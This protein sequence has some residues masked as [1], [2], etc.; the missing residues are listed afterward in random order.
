MQA[1][2]R[3][4]VATGTRAD[5][6]LLSPLC[7]RLQQS[8]S[9]EL[10]VVAANMHLIERFG[11]T[12]S[13]IEADGFDIAGR[14]P[15]DGFED[16]P[17]GRTCAMAKCLADMGAQIARL[18]PDAVLLLGDR[19]E[20][21]ATASAAAMAGIPVIHIAGGETSEGAID[22]SLRHAITKLSSLHLTATDCYR[23]RVIQM[24]EQPERVV[25][26]GA[27]GVWNGLKSPV[28]TSDFLRQSLGISSDARLVAV[29]FHA[30]T[31]DGTESPA[32]RLAELLAAMDVFPQY[33]Y[34]ITAPNNDAGGEQLLQM[35]E[36]YVAKRSNAVL[37][38]SLGCQRY[39]RLLRDAVMVLGNS[40]SG[41]VEAPSEGTPTVDIGCRQQ[42]RVAGPSV[43]H[44]GDSRNQIIDAMKLAASEQMQKLAEE[45]H[46][47]YYRPD[48]LDIMA[49]SIEKFMAQLPLSPKKFYDLKNDK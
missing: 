33:T 12:V 44:C 29:T 8:P 3:I 13:E 23:N 46:N 20:M 49:D 31:A 47:P 34:I 24:G 9:V 17:Q 27:I 14:V 35:L 18:K 16:N 21:L 6:G 1:K 5:W 11:A 38:R 10:S 15:M 39:H 37:V 40:S 42:G 4:M 26:T 22:D 30:A 32:K 45:R 2:K 36:D 48:T 43:I 28:A 7:R 25:N 19:Y 41:I